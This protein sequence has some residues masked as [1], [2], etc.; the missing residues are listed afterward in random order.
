MHLAAF[1]Q[2]LDIQNKPPPP[3]LQSWPSLLLNGRVLLQYRGVIPSSTIIMQV[4]VQDT[5]IL[6]MNLSQE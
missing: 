1:I 3:P 6:H 4:Y 5:E 2:Y